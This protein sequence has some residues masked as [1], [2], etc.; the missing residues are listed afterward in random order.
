MNRQYRPRHRHV[1]PLFCHARTVMDEYWNRTLLMMYE[2]QFYIPRP[3]SEG[4]Q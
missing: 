1:T 2:L 3:Y 4:V